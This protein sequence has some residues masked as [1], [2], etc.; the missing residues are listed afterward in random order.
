MAFKGICYDK[1]RKS[2]YI[3][4]TIKGQTI[5]IRGFSSRNDVI[6]NYDMAIEKWKREHELTA[7][8]DLFENVASN[9]IEF[10]RLGKSPRTADRERTQ[11]RTFWLPRF[12]GQLI[13]YVYKLDRLKIIYTDI[14]DSNDLNVRKKHDIV[15]TFL[16][17]THYAYINHLISKELYEET[18]LIFQ[19]IN[20]TKVV[21]NERRVIPKCDLDAFL[22]HIRHKNEKDYILFALLVNCGL[23]VSELLGLC[24]DCFVDGK[25]VIKRQLLVNGFLSDKLKTK[26]SYRSVPINKELQELIAK[27][28]KDN[29]NRFYKISHTQFKRLLYKYEKE[30]NIKQYVPHEFRHT[31]CFEKAK[32]CENIADVVYISKICGH[33]VNVF[34]NTYCNHLDNSLENKFF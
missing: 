20:Y 11:I 17:L 30:A 16:Q 12:K 6:E 14:K 34:L 2:W 24:N 13:K 18:N 33:S 9:Y 3:H 8:Q 19:P 22:S 28:K 26:Q 31:F 27:H 10:V 23:R 5:T 1:K 4:T 21:K 7:S 29:Q 25:V 15:Y 32:K